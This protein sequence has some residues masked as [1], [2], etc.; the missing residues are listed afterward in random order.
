MTKSAHA[1][2]FVSAQTLQAWQLDGRP[3]VILD[4]RFD[5]SV[6][7]AETLANADRIP[8]AIFVDVNVEAAGE[9][10][11]QTGRLPLPD[12]TALQRDARRWGVG[13]ESAVVVY[14]AVKGTSAARLWW[15]LRWAGHANVQI[16]D[17]GFA[18]WKDAGLAVT[19]EAGAVK[20]G[21]VSLSAG[22][23]PSL[24]ADQAFAVAKAGLLLDARAL[25]VYAGVPGSRETGHI[26][27]ARSLPAGK[28]QRANGQAKSPDELRDV[29]RIAGIDAHAQND[30][31]FYCGSGVAAAYGIAALA[32]IGVDAKLYAG[33]WSEWIKNPARA[34]EQGA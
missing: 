17:G 23:L 2:P 31:G 13:P 6:E 25:D 28:L 32:S 1:S 14:D 4:A 24:D 3:L 7:T 21:E 18:A 16:L 34:V 9:P 12:I 26:P 11:P 30:V 29:L 10:G 33:S 20:R 5:T 15:V 8:G 27:G 19:R 22:H